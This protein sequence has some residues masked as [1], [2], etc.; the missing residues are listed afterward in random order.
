MRF[1]TDSR[2]AKYDDPLLGPGGVAVDA[3]LEKG[4]NNRGWG[5]V[6]VAPSLSATTAS[7]RML[8]AGKLGREADTTLRGVAMSLKREVPLA[9]RAPLAGKLGQ[10]L[11]V[12]IEL[13]A[14]E[15]SPDYG[16]LQLFD[17]D[18]DLGG[19]LLASQRV[20]GVSGGEKTLEVIA[21]RPRQ[22]GDRV[23]FARYVGAGGR[24]QMLQVPV[25]IAP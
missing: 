2:W 23:L 19:Q 9:P 20:Q 7:K 8:A 16:I 11:S 6:R 21:W 22:R 25:R 10:S 4:Q 5:M 12:A 13:E 1:S 3:D 17:G 24:T 14:G 15:M 18:P